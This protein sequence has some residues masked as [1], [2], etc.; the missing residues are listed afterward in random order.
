MTRFLLV[1]HGTHDLLAMNV[2]AGRQPGISLNSAGREEAIHI[3][4]ALSILPF[5]A[6]Y[7]SPIQRALETAAPLA[8]KLGLETE[9][10]EEFIEIDFGSWTNHTFDELD[11][12]AEWQ[13]WNSNR[14]TAFTPA[15]DSMLAVQNRGVKKMVEIRMNHRLVAIFTHGDVIRALLAHYLGLPLDLLDRL[16]VEPASIS[17]IEQDAHSIRVRNINADAATIASSSHADTTV[18]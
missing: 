9:R 18:C 13:E 8:E 11:H 16:E 15:G 3:A 2:I 6:I 12:F 1:R 17:V 7:S 14:S 4:D 10:A 5:D